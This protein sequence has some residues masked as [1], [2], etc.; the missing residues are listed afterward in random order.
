VS[1][2]V[3]LRQ[4]NPE[5]KFALGIEAKTGR[6]VTLLAD[7]IGRG[8]RSGGQVWYQTV[9]G[10]DQNIDLLVALPTGT[11]AVALA[12]GVKANLWRGLLVTGSLLITL[13]NDG[14]R[15]PVTAVGGFEWAFRSAS[16]PSIPTHGQ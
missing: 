11:T 10:L 3:T 1:L 13:A 7:V 4:K 16:T 14:L 9:R 8:L 15:S 12:P 2:R 6:T 5:W